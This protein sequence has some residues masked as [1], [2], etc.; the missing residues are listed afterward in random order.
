MKKNIILEKIYYS[1]NNEA[2]IINNLSFEFPSG[3]TI[4]ILGHSGCGKSTLLQMI[5]GILKPISGNIT[6]DNNKDL[7]GN[8]FAAPDEVLEGVIEKSKIL[9]INEYI[10]FYPNELSGGLK[11][12]AA[13][14]RTI[15]QKSEFILLDEPFA[16][17]DAIT[18]MELY[19]WLE[20]LKKYIKK[21]IILVTHDID[22]AIFLSDKVIIMGSGKN[23]FRFQKDISMPHP[24]SSNINMS[25]EFLEIRK[26]LY[27]RL[28][29]VR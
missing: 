24:R 15:I 11:Q 2:P 22:E 4:A 16:S 20:Q 6:I 29:E 8:I 25:G 17:L 5:S 9:G 21:S 26:D 14:L 1:F 7:L 3:Q 19:I 12:R 23:N 27:C 13:F 18:R 28:E 10:D